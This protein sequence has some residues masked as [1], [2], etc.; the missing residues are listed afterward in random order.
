MKHDARARHPTFGGLVTNLVTQSSNRLSNCV[1]FG[2]VSARGCCL[3][4]YEARAIQEAEY[5]MKPI[6]K[7]VLIATLGFLIFVLMQVVGGPVINPACLDC[8]ARAGFPF[9]YVQEASRSRADRVIW[10][11]LLGDLALAI[12]LSA[13]AMWLCQRRKISN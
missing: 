13:C 9:A 3:H 11:G 4:S 10:S 8:G 2:S 1:I 5:A 7:A 12:G 6:R